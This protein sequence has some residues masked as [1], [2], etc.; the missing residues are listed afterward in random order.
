MSRGGAGAHRP[1][2]G[3]GSR[4]E[5]GK[6]GA[7]AGVLADLRARIERGELKAGE[8]LPAERVLAERYGC[9]QAT[10]NKAIATLLVEGL[11]ARPSPRTVRV[12][13]LPGAAR[14]RLTVMSWLST[15]VI[16]GDTWA[17]LRA[18]FEARYP[19]VE[20]VSLSVPFPIFRQ[21]LAELIGAGD[22]PDVM[23][24]HDTW[25]S[26]LADGGALLR[27]DG[28]LSPELL[29]D[30]L[31]WKTH[32]NRFRDASYA[33]DW[34]LAPRL[35]FVN[36]TVLRRAGLD[37]DRPPRTVDELRAAAAAVWQKRLVQDG[38]PVYGFAATGAEG[39]ATATLVLPFIYAFGG[40]LLDDRGR[41]A[42]ASP[43]SAAALRWFRSLVREGGSPLELSAWD[44]RRLFGRDRAAFYFDASMGRGFFRKESG[45]GAG[46][47]E[48][49]GFVPLPAGPLGRTVNLNTNHSLAIASQ[50][51]HPELALAFVEHILGDRE[52]AVRYYE[53]EGLVPARGSFLTLPAFREPYA[54]TVLEQAMLNARLPTSYPGFQPALVFLCDAIR[55][56]LREDGPVEPILEEAARNLGVVFHGSSEPRAVA[57]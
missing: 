20:I 11:L 40:A 26:G 9:A 13:A 47:D 48:R 5:R 52:L 25:T 37:P 1:D 50:T 43:E 38:E 34:G 41:V 33:I 56:V 6:G 16:G 17:S 49:F 7:F 54:E 27:L 36:R 46:A 42:L 28:R 18:S 8:R 12:A 29:A 3:V 24:I 14:R 15:E 22:A 10:V 57:R 23:L 31:T 39:E 44:A 51:T 53:E 21:R 4:S 32:L 2:G 35:L 19:A 30:H 45:L 55:R